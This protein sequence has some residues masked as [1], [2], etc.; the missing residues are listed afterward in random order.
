MEVGVEVEVEARVE[1]EVRVEVQV[2]ARVEVHLCSGP[3]T[4]GSSTKP[5]W[6]F[7]TLD[8]SPALRGV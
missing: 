6:Y 5:C 7:F 4:M 2:E 8:T 3:S 1:V